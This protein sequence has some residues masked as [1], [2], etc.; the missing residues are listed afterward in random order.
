MLSHNGKMTEADVIYSDV[1]FTKSTGNTTGTAVSPDE[2]TYAEVRKKEP[3]TELPGSQQQAEPKGGSKVTSERV[4]IAVLSALLAAAAI[5]L[6]FTSG[7]CLKCLEGWEKHGGHC[8]YF[9]TKKSSWNNSR[10]ECRLKGGDLVQ[11]D[12]R[13]EQSF[14]HQRLQDKMDYPED[15]FWI[16]LTD[17][18]EEGKWLWVDGSPLDESLKFWSTGEPD[19][20]TGK[21]GEIIDGEDCAR[22]GEQGSTD[23][24]SWFDK[25][26]KSDERFICEKS[27]ENGKLKCE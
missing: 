12:S 8:Y 25:F 3:S 9:S 2:T 10:E 15:K 18:Q 4:A 23:L 13:E 7:R 22:M 16:G 11:I 19:N 20:W 1:K 17:S 27:A 24:N 21:N 6:G 5:A 14:L 26:C